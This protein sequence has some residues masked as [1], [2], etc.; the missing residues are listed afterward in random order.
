MKYAYYSSLRPIG[1]GT[2]PTDGLVEIHNFPERLPV[3]GG[4]AW[5]WAEYDR[6]LTQKE[7]DSYDLFSAFNLFTARE[8][9][10]L[11]DATLDLLENTGKAR[12]FLPGSTDKTGRQ[13]DAYRKEALA[14]H[15][16]ACFL[17]I[18]SGE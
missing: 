5:G 8:A 6:G 13:I 2:C 4:E 3:P 16:K 15:E 18:D 14:V 11:S 7:L 17:L 9:Q 10:I 12:R 1:P